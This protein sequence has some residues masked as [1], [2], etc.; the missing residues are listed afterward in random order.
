[1]G[2]VLLRYWEYAQGYYGDGTD[3]LTPELYHLRRSLWVVRQRYS[4][5]PAESFG[6]LALR[7]CQAALVEDGLVRR[8][9]NQHVGRIKRVFK[10]AVQRGLVSMR[11]SDIDRMVDPWVYRPEHHDIEWAIYIG[12]QAQALLEPILDAARVVLGHT[13]ADT[14]AIDAEV[15]Q[16]KAARAM[17]KPGERTVRYRRYAEF[18]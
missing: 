13:G 17:R 14:T 15:D 10:W 18:A 4:R 7:A 11:G 12:P 1:M 9:V 8:S 5:E 6:P 3:K 2:D 16:Q